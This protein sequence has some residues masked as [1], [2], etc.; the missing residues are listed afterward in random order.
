M[1]PLKI[2]TLLD[3]KVVEQNRIEYKEGWNPNDIIH[4]ICAFANDYHNMNGG[5]IVIGVRE[6][7]G[8]PQLPPTGLLKEQLDKIQQEVFQYSNQIIPRYIPKMEVVEYQE[9]YL[10]YLW[11]TA[12]DSGPYQAPVDVY[13]DKNK[14]NSIIGLGLP[15]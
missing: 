8:V 10:L 12:G 1:I 5:Y 3:G 15:R 4:T 7:N 6:Q 9:K 14:K 2:E 13:S 11:C